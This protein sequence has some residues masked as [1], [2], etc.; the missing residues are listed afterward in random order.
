MIVRI[1]LT[2]NKIISWFN[3][4][5]SG[6]ILLC[7]YLER[8]F[9]PSANQSRPDSYD[10]A[11]SALP[12]TSAFFLPL[13]ATAQKTKPILIPLPSEIFILIAIQTTLLIRY[14]CCYIARHG[15]KSHR[16]GRWM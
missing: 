12:S 13:P 5:R 2:R 3:I 8:F 10:R 16:R 7:V 9:R 4:I 14:A 15:T 6:D 1:K 11:D